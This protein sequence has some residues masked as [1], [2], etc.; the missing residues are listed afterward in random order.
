[1]SNFTELAS[2]LSLVDFTSLDVVYTFSNSLHSLLMNDNCPN[3]E[4]IIHVVTYVD[5]NLDKLLEE[6]EAQVRTEYLDNEEA[7][8][9]KE[10]LEDADFIVENK[11]QMGDTDYLDYLP[12]Y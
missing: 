3:E 1:M 8:K 7:K 12:L 9:Y 10:P 4:F 6:Y 11:I 2:Q 5:K